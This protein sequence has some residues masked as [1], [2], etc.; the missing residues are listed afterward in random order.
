MN[1]AYLEFLYNLG[2]FNIKLGLS[3]IREMLNRMGNPHHHPRIIHIAGTNGKGSTLATIEQLLLDTGFTTGS[4]ISPHLISF[5]E[6]FRICGKSVTDEDLD[7][8]FERICRSCDID[9][10]LTKPESRDGSISPTFFEFAIALAFEVFRSH[11]V[12][13]II[14]ETGLGGRLDATNVVENPLACI[15]TRIGY[16]HQEFLGETLE[17]ITWEKMGILKTNS[18][19]FVTQQLERVKQVIK[20]HCLETGIK[21]FFS[22]EHFSADYSDVSHETIY[23]LVVRNH[24][25]YTIPLEIPVPSQSLAGDHQKHN[26]AT[27]LALYHSIIPEGRWLSKDR[28]IMSLQNVTWRGRLEYLDESKRILLDAAHNESSIQSLFDF[29]KQ[30]HHDQRILFAIGWKKDKQ[31]ADVI[32]LNGLYHVEFLP[33][34]QKNEKALDADKVLELLTDM[35]FSTLQAIDITELIAGVAKE[36]LPE[37]DL[38]VI[39]GSI[40]L[41]GEFLEQWQTPQHH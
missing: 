5:N 1:A 25:N 26:T 13:F 8:A 10:D 17:E 40:Y 31:I 22:P 34:K 29:L 28:I 15:L 33:I 3:T 4:T 18:P 32:D 7:Y 35:N 12:D 24:K 6:R 14:L 36:S 2:Q 9:L 37:H 11:K 39:A 27:A 19:V 23:H 16:D 21:A 38:L 41:L 30:Q 20:N